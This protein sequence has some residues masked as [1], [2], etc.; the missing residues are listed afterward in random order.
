MAKKEEAP[1]GFESALKRLEEIVERMESGEADLD[2]MI[3]LFEEGQSLVKTCTAKLNE[4]EK[5]IEKIA[6][7]GAGGVTVEPLELVAE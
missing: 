2:A 4:V 7:D 1:R 5:K 6:E 3:A